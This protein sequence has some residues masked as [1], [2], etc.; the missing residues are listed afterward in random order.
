MATALQNVASLL[1]N[2][3]AFIDWSIVDK[4]LRMAKLRGP[5]SKRKQDAE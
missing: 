3:A 4:Y 5:P 2:Q 1:S